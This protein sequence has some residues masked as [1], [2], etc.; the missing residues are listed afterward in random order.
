MDATIVLNNGVHMPRVGF[1]V[2]QIEDPKECQ[3]SVEAAL[4]AGYRAIDTAALYKNERAVGAAIAASGIPRSELFITTKVWHS[5]TSYDGALTSFQASLDKLGLDYLD[6]F[7]I[8]QPFNDIYG[9]WRALEE[10]YSQERTR[11]IGVSNFYPSRLADLIDHAEVIPAVNQVEAHVLYQQRELKAFMNEHG[12]VMEAWAPLARGAENI[13]ENPVLTKIAAAHGKSV[14][15]VILR[16]LMERDI[17]IIPKSS[18][19]ERIRENFALFDFSLSAQEMELIANL[20]R[21]KPLFGDH[22]E[23]ATTKRLLARHVNLDD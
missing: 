15:Q 21:G 1:G 3:A 11:A 4:E 16:W 17:V 18:H 9:A 20:D 13:F 23:L 8:H 5:Q 2:Y 6:L 7:L 14:A 22:R 19:A 12:I 10:L